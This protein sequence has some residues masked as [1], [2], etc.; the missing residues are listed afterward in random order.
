[1]VGLQHS[2]SKK[3]SKEKAKKSSIVHKSNMKAIWGTM[4]DK[5]VETNDCWAKDLKKTIKL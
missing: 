4:K 3:V 1:M 2:S 5:I